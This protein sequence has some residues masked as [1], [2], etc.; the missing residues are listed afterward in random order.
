MMRW[1]ARLEGEI[2]QAER[3]DMELWTQL[4]EVQ[5]EKCAVYEGND[6]RAW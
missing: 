1:R 4:D 2:V 5:R 6:R 3:K